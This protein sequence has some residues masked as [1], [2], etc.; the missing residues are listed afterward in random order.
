[1]KRYIIFSLLLVT[2]ACF[3]AMVPV[4]L[5]ISPAMSYSVGTGVTGNF[6]P[7][8]TSVNNLYSSTAC[9]CSQPLSVISVAITDAAE[10]SILLCNI[11]TNILSD[12]RI[13]RL[14]EDGGLYVGV[15]L[16]T[17]PGATTSAAGTNVVQVVLMNEHGT[18]YAQNSFALASGIGALDHYNVGF[19]VSN[20]DLANGNSSV[21]LRGLRFNQALYYKQQSKAVIP[22]PVA[23]VG[24]GTSHMVYANDCNPGQ[25][26]F[27]VSQASMQ[28]MYSP[29][30]QLSA[31]LNYVIVSVADA[32]GTCPLS[33]TFSHNFI[34]TSKIKSLYDNQGL[35]VG[36]NLI[37]ST[38]G[39]QVQAVL[40]D[41]CG[42]V[43][44]QGT[45]PIA[46]GVGG[47][48]NYTVTFGNGKNI[49]TTQAVPLTQV[50][51]YL[52]P[53]SA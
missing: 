37:Q 3:I 17:L 1:M 35:Y 51:P 30:C 44:A 52:Q 48:I 45:C 8:S 7:C 43:C 16:L 23:L 49:V 15:N 2:P 33:F 9:S 13:A 14:I 26:V 36:V 18:V 29:V 21:G 12:P 46:S 34:R 39:N 50:V 24:L 5:Q 31:E 19:N 22:Q 40:M 42:T 53:L 6:L 47:F 20:P 10:A 41:Q 25:G 32:T 4:P 28:N 27:T 11:G 38:K